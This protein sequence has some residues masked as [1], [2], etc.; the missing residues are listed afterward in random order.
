MRTLGTMKILSTLFVVTALTI[1][2]YQMWP[3]TDATSSVPVAVTAP[4]VPAEAS[5]DFNQD[6]MP[7]LL[8]LVE[9]S[10]PGAAVTPAAD[11]PKVAATAPT[12][13]A[14]SAP[15]AVAS[16]ASTAPAALAPSVSE[17][18]VVRFEDNELIAAVEQG[19]I[20]AT[21]RSNGRER[22]V[23]HLRNN[24]PA[25]LRILVP[26]GQ[27][28]ESGRQTVVVLRD[29]KVELMPAQTVDLTVATAA[30]HSGN[31]L[32]ETSYKLSYQN[33]PRVSGFLRW[34]GDH[35]EVNTPTVQTAILILGEN[36]SIP[37]LAKFAPANGVTSKLDTEAFRV[38]TAELI[39]ALTA[40][41]DS[42]V[43]TDGL[44][45]A[46]DS[47]LRIEAMIEPLSREMAKRFYAITEETEWEFWRHE[48]L[49]GE[50]GTRHYA[51]FG[52][53]R[54]Y[55]DI[56][57]DMLPKWVRE[58]K[59]HPV[60]RMS[61][62]QALADTQRPE[63]LP[64]LRQLGE[65]LGADTELGKAAAQAATYLDQRLSQLSRVPVVAF[66]GRSGVNGL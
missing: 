30:L 24:S 31:T 66:R 56:A 63:A 16:V 6:P 25:P 10:K 50:P 42:G 17:A 60:Y 47:Q 54:F 15:V 21:L 37:A 28:L 5:I 14:E 1:G 58:P 4:V 52:I 45:L 43:K 61:A 8:S 62:L 9:P 44:A 11:A 22:I 29:T 64:L 7:E 39:G 53:A 3:K 65:E 57:M 48:L 18:E 35:P 12:A 51:L 36:L 55:P 34:L 13:P 32:G 40:L 20:Q 46:K 19:V 41:R 2:G 26:G 33:A 49:E 23:A 27:V 59:T 38:D